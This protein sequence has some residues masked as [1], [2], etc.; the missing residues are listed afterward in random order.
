LGDKPKLA[1]VLGAFITQ[2][3]SQV[4]SALSGIGPLL[5]GLR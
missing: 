4:S 3:A 2:L 5:G 1:G